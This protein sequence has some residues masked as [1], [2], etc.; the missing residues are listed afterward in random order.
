MALTKQ[1]LKKIVKPKPRAGKP[2]AA[3][4]NL[5]KTLCCR[6]PVQ[7][8]V[9]PKPCAAKMPAV[10]LTTLVIKGTPIRRKLALS[11]HHPNKVIHT[12]TALAVNTPSG[13]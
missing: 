11:R 13:S 10:L 4:Q 6:N 1:T 3:K 12:V 9:L 2:C 7:N 8:P 5:C